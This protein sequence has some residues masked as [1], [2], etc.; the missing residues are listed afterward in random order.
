MVEPR[1]ISDYINQLSVDFKA[2]ALL[3]LF[4]DRLDFTKILASYEGQLKRAWSKDV[5][6][7]DVLNLSAGPEFLNIKLNRDGIYDCL[8]EAIFHDL[9]GKDCSTGSDM[10]KESMR[11]KVQEKESRLFFQ[12]IENEIFYQGL[13]LSAE[14]NRLFELIHAHKLMGL[15]PHF[16]EIEAGLHPAYIAKMIKLI[17]LAHLIAGNATL[18]A[19]CLEFVFE[20]K[21]CISSTWPEEYDLKSDEQENVGLVGNLTLG[22]DSLVGNLVNGP[23]KLFHVKIG[24]V[25]K[26]ETIELIMN[27]S[28]NNFLNTFYGFFMPVEVDL[29]TQFFFKEED[30]C[31][32]LANENETETSYLGLNSVI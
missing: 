28:L 15:I 17:P 1:E 32:V 2:E 9:A 4:E 6:K 30:A 12:P 11:I 16:F 25:E 18:T 19:Q 22:F 24:P 7:A 26:R 14:E 31:F 21:V 20:E 13:L 10:A 3:A 29:K 27:G 5:S 23:V 8:P